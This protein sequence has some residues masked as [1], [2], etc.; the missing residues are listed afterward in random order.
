MAQTVAECLTAAEDSV[1]VINDINTNGKKSVYVAGSAEA[2]TTWTQAEINE[3][4]QR[5]VDH[6]ET[7]LAYE[8]VDSDDD[9]PNVKGS[10]SSKKTTCSGGVTTGKA[11]IA[12][13]S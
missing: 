8:P 2:D 6:L 7:I 12:A 9:T 10:S 13:N 3:V 11:Y 5:N 4:V 1:T